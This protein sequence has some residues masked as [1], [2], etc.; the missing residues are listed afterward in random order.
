MK[1]IKNTKIIIFMLSI[2]SVGCLQNNSADFR[3]ETFKVSNS[4][5]GYRI[6]KD[7]QSFIAQKYIPAVDGATPFHSEKDAEKTGEL[8][9]RKLEKGKMP[10]VSKAELDSLK[11]VL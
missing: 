8:M 6:L 10:S 1:T 3:L 5:W 2:I 7:D 4:G 11:I 9:I